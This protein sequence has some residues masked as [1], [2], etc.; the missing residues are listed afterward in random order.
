VGS[1]TSLAS[2]L[3]VASWIDW[4]A[5]LA[6]ARASGFA[7]RL[8]LLGDFAQSHTLALLPAVRHE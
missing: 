3:C 1:R 4:P 7:G 5:T 2:R 8:A 6:P